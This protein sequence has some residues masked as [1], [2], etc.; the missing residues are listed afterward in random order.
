MQEI[1]KYKKF[2]NTY[3]K[4]SDTRNFQKQES[5]LVV[6]IAGKNDPIAFHWNVSSKTVS[7]LPRYT[8]VFCFISWNIFLF[9]GYAMCYK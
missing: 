2:L 5:N 1:F 9:V 6:I 4:F 3:K 8:Y 7:K